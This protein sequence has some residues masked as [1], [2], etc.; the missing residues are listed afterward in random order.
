MLALMN[1][2]LLHL[3]ADVFD[4][5]WWLRWNCVLTVIP[6]LLLYFEAL[7]FTIG[8]LT[9][10]HRGR[11]RC[12]R[13]SCE[14]LCSR[15]NARAAVCARIKIGFALLLSGFARWRPISNIDEN[16]LAAWT[17]FVFALTR[18]VGSLSTISHALST[19]TLLEVAF[20]DAVLRIL[21]CVSQLA[22]LD[23]IGRLRREQ[24]TTRLDNAAARAGGSS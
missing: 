11:C 12:C 7:R 5:I 6:A 17:G 4:D 24:L 19:V 8:S 15:R 13:V 1:T 21:G 23:F 2:N 18:T 9:L 14:H 16:I 3:V 20:L 22:A 10:D